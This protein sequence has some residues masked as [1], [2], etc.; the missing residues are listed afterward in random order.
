MSAPIPFPK[1]QVEPIWGSF[2]PSEAIA[3]PQPRKWRVDGMI[4]QGEVVLLA[5]APKSAKSMV[6]QQLLTSSAIGAPWVGKYIE[7]G[8]GLGLFLEDDADELLRRQFIICDAY[9]MD[10]SELDFEIE[11]N[12]RQQAIHSAEPM[13]KKLIEFPRGSEEPRWTPL[14][15]QLWEKTAKVGYKIIVVDTATKALGWPAKWSGDKASNVIEALRHQLAG[16]DAA[17]IITD[18]TNRVDPAGFAGTN[19]W[20]GSVRAAMNMRIPTDE[21]TREPIRGERILRDLG[22]NYG[23]WE[24]IPLIWERD[25]LVPKAPDKLDRRPRTTEEK[26]RFNYELLGY[27][28]KCVEQD[29]SPVLLDEAKRMSFVQRVRRVRGCAY[30]DIYA[31]QDWAL[32]QGLAERVKVKFNGRI[33]KCIRP[34][35]VRY[36]GE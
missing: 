18:H 27:M 7:Q 25:I 2:F 4:P 3:R 13:P 11:L 35:D 15:E 6:L 36:D 12:P 33:Y 29:D 17:M 19:T 24:P 5:G 30:N 10:I 28:R 31:A 20:H 9:G 26:I 8:R 32:D 16:L 34:K 1:Q 23:N 22:G 14:G 21:M